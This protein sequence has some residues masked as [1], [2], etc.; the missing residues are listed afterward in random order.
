MV[1]VVCVGVCGCVCGW[2]GGWVYIHTSYYLDPVLLDAQSASHLLTY[3]HIWVLGLC[4]HKLELVQLIV[5]VRCPSSLGLL[6][7]LNTTATTTTRVAAEFSIAILPT[8]FFLLLLLPTHLFI[9]LASNSRVVV[10]TT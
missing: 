4:K 2:V 10:S 9:M 8:P 3:E 7:L 6:R 5:T 1:L